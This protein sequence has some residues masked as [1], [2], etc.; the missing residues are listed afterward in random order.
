MNIK[1]LIEKLEDIEG[2]TRDA[3][4]CCPEG[5]IGTDTS[6]TMYYINHVQDELEKLIIELGNDKEVWK[7]KLSKVWNN[8]SA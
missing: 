3:Y 4:S 7:Y 2:I 8:E 1:K 6:D 5:D